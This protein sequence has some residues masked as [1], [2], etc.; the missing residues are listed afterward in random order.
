VGAVFF[1]E[2]NKLLGFHHPPPA[3][4][5]RTDRPLPILILFLQ[6]PIEAL[7]MLPGRLPG[8]VRI[9]FFQGLHQFLQVPEIFPQKRRRQGKTLVCVEHIFVDHAQ[10]R[11]KQGVAH[12]FGHGDVEPDV[13]PG[14]RP[15]VRASFPEEA[16]GLFEKLLKP[17][18][19]GLSNRRRSKGRHGSLHFFAKLG[20]LVEGDRAALDQQVEAFGNPSPF[21]SKTRSASRIVPRP[22]WNISLS[23]ISEG[24]W[25]P[26]LRRPS[27]IASWI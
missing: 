4:S 15:G 6:M 2:Q 12:D 16:A 26:A 1:F 24:S 11:H 8:A 14:K 13:D 25:S 5:G 27:K 21:S 10:D 18:D 20:Q 19:V 17:F 3:S 22:V 7:H 23:F 9:P